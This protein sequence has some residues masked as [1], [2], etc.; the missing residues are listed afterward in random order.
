[1]PVYKRYSEL[2]HLETFEEKFNYL[3]LAGSI[4]KETFG[5]D[6]YLNQIL[7]RSEEWKQ[8]RQKIILRDNGC[9]LGVHGYEIFSKPIIHHINPITLEELLA[10]DP[11]IFDP[12]NLITTTLQTHNA[13]HYGSYENIKQEP[14]ERSAN[15]TSPW[16]K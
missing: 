1:M 11:K 14:V 7:Y 3:K 2:K 12:E 4:G 16:R 10:N 8:L 6:R 9:D 5:F 15:D 13:I